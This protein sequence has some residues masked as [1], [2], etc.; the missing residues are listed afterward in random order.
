MT[1]E[2]RPRRISPSLGLALL[3]IALGFALRL[4]H[5]DFQSI[6]RDEADSLE[7]TSSFVS[8]RKLFTQPGHNAPLYYALL[9]GW[10][11]AAG[12]DLISARFFSALW[13]TCGLALLWAL[14]RRFIQP[15]AAGWALLFA[16]CSPFWVWYSQE[17]R[18]Y[19]PLLTTALLVSWLY[20]DALERGGMRRWAGCVLGMAMLVYLHFMALWLVPA[21]F[22]MGI[23]LRPRGRGGWPAWAA[24]MAV[25][26]LPAVPLAGWGMPLLLSSLFQTGHAPA[27]WG[28]MTAGLVLGFTIGPSGRLPAW[29]A[30]PALFLALLGT[31]GIW[32]APRLAPQRLLLAPRLAPQRLLLALLAWLGVPAVGLMALSMVKP[33]FAERY[34]IFTLPALLLL[35]ALGTAWLRRTWRP[36]AVAAVAAVLTASLIGIA[37]QDTQTIK[38]DFRGA[39]GYFLAHRQAGDLVL[40]LIPQAQNAFAYYAP[41]DGAAY[42]PAPFANG[43][44]PAELDTAIRRL[45][46]EHRRVW[47]VES[48]PAWWDRAGA[49]RAWLC[50]HARGSR[51]IAF[52][53]ITLI[54]YSGVQ[55]F[56]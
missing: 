13:G 8:L 21:Y 14:C 27:S 50:A 48:E 3:L 5:L 38:P 30:A 22:I 16:A 7:F 25:L 35:M 18:V 6:W 31:A 47:L 17:A 53:L 52:H 9:A 26:C 46:G 19:A 33:L 56:P 28:D 23:L 41:A 44:P 43:L 37:V 12:R 42:A 15:E 2:R 55:S 40:F 32:L 29:L 36:L 49:V 4:W 34:L 54:E 20:L 39:A 1:A 10:Q 45:V 11:T 24:A 51:E